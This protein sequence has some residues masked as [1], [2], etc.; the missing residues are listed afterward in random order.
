M[1]SCV[2]ILSGITQSYLFAGVRIVESLSYVGA[3]VSHISL[4]CKLHAKVRKLNNLPHLGQ[5]P[6]PV[7]SLSHCYMQTQCISHTHTH[8]STQSH[9]STTHKRFLIPGWSEY[10]MVHCNGTSRWSLIGLD[11]WTSLGDGCELL[12]VVSQ[13]GVALL[14]LI[15]ELFRHFFLI[16]GKLF[17]PVMWD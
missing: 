4:T 14:R 7:Y 3:T 8:T 2:Y 1:L 15:F 13:W 17:M 16:W 9:T 5:C 12:V 6:R 11:H 10:P